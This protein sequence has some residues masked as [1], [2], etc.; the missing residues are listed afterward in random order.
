[1]TNAQLSLLDHATQLLQEQRVPYEVDTQTAAKLL[2][3]S[4]STL[5]RAKNS[6]NLPYSR[7]VTSYKV[8]AYFT[9]RLSRGDRWSVS[10][11]KMEECNFG[12]TQN[13]NNH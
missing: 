4:V 5:N 3:I 10:F 7:T 1:M 9:G 12:S 6:G 8:S 13:Q 2:R 11:T